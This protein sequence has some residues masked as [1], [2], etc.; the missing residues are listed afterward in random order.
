MK[1][2]LFVLLMI[3]STTAFGQKKYNYDCNAKPITVVASFGAGV[4]RGYLL[5]YIKLGLWQTNKPSGF[6]L[7]GGYGDVLV[8]DINLTKIPFGPKPDSYSVSESAFAELGYKVRINN[9]LLLH[10][11][12]GTN[13]V[14]QY[15]GGDVLF[16]LTTNVATGFNYKD[17]AYGGAVYFAF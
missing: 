16:Q 9:F 10:G 11:Y 17:N 3:L 5:Q 14:R 6:T 4:N 13:N 7:F 2:I 12:V 8:K 1:N 15:V